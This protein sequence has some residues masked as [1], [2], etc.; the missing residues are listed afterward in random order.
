MFNL[1]DNALHHRKEKFMS[2][3]DIVTKDYTNDCRIFADAFNHYIYKGKQVIKPEN[4]KPLDTTITGIPYG[5][6]GAGVPVQRFRDGLKSVTAME[7][8]KA[9]YLLLGVE[10]Q[11]EI[12]YTMHIFRPR[13]MGW[14]YEPA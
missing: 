8:E 7:D 12:H 2:V 5:A 3:K 4:L 10:S 13:R 1:Q 6:D 9:V 11:V 14:P